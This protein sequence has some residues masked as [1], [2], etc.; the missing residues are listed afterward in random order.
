MSKFYAYVTSRNDWGSERTDALRLKATDAEAA[1][2]EVHAFVVGRLTE[3]NSWRPSDEV[4][5]IESVEIFDSVGDL[6]FSL[7]DARVEADRILT[8]RAQRLARFE[9]A[10]IEDMERKQL[11]D[12]K[13][14]YE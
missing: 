10:R 3:G 5:D 1:R 11:A 9:E 8:E 14:K 13:A 2:L 6:Q 4:L 12:L 7:A